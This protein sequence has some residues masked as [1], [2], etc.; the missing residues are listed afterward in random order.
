M[1]KSNELNE[2]GVAL[3]KA[4]GQIK[5]A[6]RDSD[7]PFFKSRYADL[8]AVWD[9]CRKPL[10]DNGL[11]IVQSVTSD[12][13]HHYVETMML[14]SSGQWINDTVKLTL[15]ADDMQAMGSAITYAR[16]YSLAAF[17]GVAP[18]DDDDGNAASGKSD[19]KPAQKPQEAKPATQQAKVVQSDTHH[20]P[21]HNVPFKHM[22][23]GDKEWYSHKTDDGWCNERDVINKADAGEEKTTPA[24]VEKGLKLS[25]QR[26]RIT[27]GFNKLGITNQVEKVKALEEWGIDKADLDAIEIKLE[28]LISLR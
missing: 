5:N 3:A 24:D 25:Q 27:E 2:L 20:C 13:D 28:D 7:N 14:H 18:D 11:S 10:S 16:R 15:K 9:V 23:K 8:A 12:S 21:I 19:N 4:Q 22:Q 6:V 26:E 17:A 1:N